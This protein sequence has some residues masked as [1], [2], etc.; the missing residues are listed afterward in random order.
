MEGNWKI[1]SIFGIPLYIDYSWLIILVLVTIINAGD[2]NANNLAVGNPLLGW[3]TGLIMALFLFGSV[4]L[5]EL[6]HSLVAQAQGIT[7]N[8]ITLFLFGG[9]AAIERESKTPVEALNV[10]MAGPIVS[11]LL[12][13]I[14][15]SLN[16][17]FA[18]DTLAYYITAD[19]AR[20][21]QVLA[22]FNL[23]PGLPLDGGQVLK[24]I[25]WKITGDRFA[26]VFWAATTGKLLG[27]LG[28]SFGLF[29]CFFTGE[30]GLL[31]IALISWFIWRNANAYD[32]FTMLQ[33]T[34]LDLVAAD[35]MTRE[36]RVVNANLLLR[37]FV[38]EYLISDL[39]NPISY[40][41]A[42]EGRYRGLIAIKDLQA[43]E[44]YEWDIKT[45]EELAHPLT[46]IPSVEEKT[47]LVEVINKLEK[48]RD[49]RITVLS[50]AGA[51]AG[52]IDKGDLVKLVATKQ[53]LNIPEAEIK[54]VKA[55]GTY[56]SELQ[57]SAIARTIE[58]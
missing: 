13:A 17:F 31:W 7:V 15:W 4:L 55:E 53:N 16:N 52:V 25:V 22:I 58:N 9:V 8:S 42:S 47:P 29:F 19:L 35:A 44:R 21:N 5:H 49:N 48:I 18:Q 36:F 27:W 3:F 12:F 14:F 32:R 43:V 26:G 11:M 6:G 50:P 1:G 41:A 37:D 57:L 40:Y 2:V 10:A 24:A 20:I 23:I 38:A 33:K 39:S 45:L 56:P 54:R 34:L 46:E 28:M 30:I 51:V